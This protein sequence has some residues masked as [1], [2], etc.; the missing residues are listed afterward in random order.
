MRYSRTFVLIFLA[1]VALGLIKVLCGA[2]YVQ[3]NHG[4]REL[5]HAAATAGVPSG[6]RE[7]TWHFLQVSSMSA[8]RAKEETNMA[9]LFIIE[10]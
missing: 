5:P 4:M 1:L 8:I 6:R 3:H 7:S 10:E 2:G 9:T